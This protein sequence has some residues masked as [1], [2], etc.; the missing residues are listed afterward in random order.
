[1]QASSSLSRI[2]ARAWP[3]GATRQRNPFPP[4]F[5][6]VFLKNTIKK[7]VTNAITGSSLSVS[8]SMISEGSITSTLNMNRGNNLQINRKLN[9]ENTIACTSKRDITTLLNISG[10]H[11]NAGF[12]ISAGNE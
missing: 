3:T 10:L 8:T 2:C 5:A 6:R 11:M 9:C 1:M 4:F 12:N 7:R